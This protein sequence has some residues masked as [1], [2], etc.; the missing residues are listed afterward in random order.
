SIAILTQSQVI[1]REGKLGDVE[2]RNKPD[3][4]EFT[5]N[6]NCTTTVSVYGKNV[7]GQRVDAGPSL[8]SYFHNET[9]NFY[10]FGFNLTLD[11]LNLITITNITFEVTSNETLDVGQSGFRY[12]VGNQIVSYDFSDL[13]EAYNITSYSLR[14]TSPNTVVLDFEF[15]NLRL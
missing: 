3:G 14:Q 11:S 7:L 5:L 12:F 15:N 2:L 10:K 9:K 13:I 1:D 6:G 4:N 8:S